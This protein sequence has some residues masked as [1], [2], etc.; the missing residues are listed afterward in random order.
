MKKNKYKLGTQG[1]KKYAYGTQKMDTS[2]RGSEEDV[3]GGVTSGMSAGA[4]FGPVGMAA[5]AVVGGAKGV[6]DMNLKNEA[7]ERASKHNESL[8]TYRDENVGLQTAQYEKGTMGIASRNFK[9]IEAEG[10]E[11]VMKRG[12]DGK[13]LMKKNLKGP[14][15]AK[16]GIDMIA[17][18]GDVI[19][20]KKMRK[21]A[22]EAYRNNDNYKLEGM[23]SK[24]PKDVEGKAEG[25]DD[26]SRYGVTTKDK[27]FGAKDWNAAN[28]NY[29]AWLDNDSDFG[30]RFG[31]DNKST[32]IT[33]DDVLGYRKQYSDMFTDQ[34]EPTSI[35]TPQRMDSIPSMDLATP[36]VTADLMSPGVDNT[37]MIPNTP[38]ATPESI[39]G[40]IVSDTGKDRTGKFADFGNKLRMNAG[41]LYNLGMGAFGD[42]EVSTRRYIDP[43]EMQYNDMSHEDRKAAIESRAAMKGS[44]SGYRSGGQGAGAMNQIEQRYLNQMGK[45]NQNEVRRADEVNK[46]NLGQRSKAQVQNL[47]LANKYDDI[48]AQNRGMKQRFTSKGV[49]QQTELGSYDR[50]EGMMRN[51]VSEMKRMNSAQLELE[52]SKM[53]DVG[54]PRREAFKKKYGLYHR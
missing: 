23:R 22:I 7:F 12:K 6:M 38:G 40:N 31:G 47:N 18:E 28:P 33:K 20:P 19:F 26:Y 46:Y 37:E 52:L 21:E 34:P 17:E 41:S 32:P 50:Q 42:P 11:I 13:Y 53:Y 35:G 45:I 30:T 27:A 24:L 4:A 29:K 8:L 44:T 1:V 10:G 54:D 48:D 39:G 2:V 51:K 3:I 49:G 9:P 16:G 25:G 15:H 36:N 14:S 43:E 5:G